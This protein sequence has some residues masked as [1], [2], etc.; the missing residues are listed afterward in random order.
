MGEL[1]V[2]SPSQWKQGEVVQL[3]S[4][5][6]ARLK[7]PDVID[8]IMDNGKVPDVLMPL[9]FGNKGVKQGRQPN[10]DEITPDMLEMLLP[11]LRKMVKACFVEPR[12]MDEPD[13]NSIGVDDVAFADKL[14]VFQWAIGG[15]AQVAAGFPKQSAR[16]MVALPNG[17][18]DEPEAVKPVGN[19]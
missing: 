12:V 6:V 4:G 8:L 19:S 1:I 15:Q 14:W 18:H 13:D 2:T 16:N 17:A 10:A 9:I 3:P 11:T 7:R 5:C